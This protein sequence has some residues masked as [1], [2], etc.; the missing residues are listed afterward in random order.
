MKGLSEGDIVLDTGCLYER[1][2]LCQSRTRLYEKPIYAGVSVTKYPF[3]SGDQ[4]GVGKCIYDRETVESFPERF[5]VVGHLEMDQLIIDG[6]LM[7]VYKN[8]DNA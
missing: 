4:W 3:P 7:E 1:Y 5:P 6:V 8:E 2:F